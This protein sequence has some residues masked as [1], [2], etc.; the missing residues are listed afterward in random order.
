[1]KGDTNMLSSVI[2]LLI[3][4]VFSFLL[5]SYLNTP[6]NNVEPAQGNTKKFSKGQ[7]IVVL[8]LFLI[9]AL[10]LIYTILV[11][12][13][14]ENP[15]VSTIKIEEI[16]K[17]RASFTSDDL[18]LVKEAG[19]S[20]IKRIEAKTILKGDSNYLIKIEY[21]NMSKIASFLLDQSPVNYEI[22]TTNP[23]NIQKVT[24]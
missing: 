7:K 4:L 15:I 22:V 11:D 8:S 14:Y 13:S 6:I 16:Y 18:Y 12:M 5:V 21:P 20:D 1:M 10:A 9:L 3:T 24:E 17:E 23:D 2:I 19:S